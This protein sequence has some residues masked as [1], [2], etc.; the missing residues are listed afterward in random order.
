M[1]TQSKGM[2]Q[3][4]MPRK[5]TACTQN[6]IPK[7][8]TALL[9][10]A[11]VVHAHKAVVHAPEAKLGPDVAHSDAGH[12]H[13]VRQAAQLRAQQST[14]RSRGSDQKGQSQHLQVCV[15]P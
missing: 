10:D 13:V 15:C 14:K 7:P 2:N 9:T 6:V 4:S 3:L 5:A 8:W 11:H 12:G 1:R